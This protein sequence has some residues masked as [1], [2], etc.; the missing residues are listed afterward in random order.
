MSTKAKATLNLKA[1]DLRGKN[2]QELSALMA[3]QR[4]EQFKARLHKAGGEVVITHTSKMIR[5]NIA[6]IQ[7]ILTQIEGKVGKA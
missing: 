3:N 1:S 6:R 7:T 4:R 2:A 5:R